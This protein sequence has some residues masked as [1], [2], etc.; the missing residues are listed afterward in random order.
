MME[1]I[2]TRIGG[3][4]GFGIISICLFFIVFTGAILW[5]YCQEKAYLAEMGELPLRDEE[6]LI[7]K[8]GDEQHV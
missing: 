3:I 8:K 4:E 2:L 7:G 1:R 6:L 5:A